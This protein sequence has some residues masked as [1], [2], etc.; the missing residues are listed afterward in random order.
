MKF[1]QIIILTLVLLLQTNI[2]F[3]QLRTDKLKNV[4][5]NI[6]FPELTSTEKRVLANQAQIFFNDLY[7]NRHQKNIMYGESPSFS[8]GHIDPL[9]AINEIVKNVDSLTT[10]ELEIG[11]Q[12]IFINQRDLHL[13][14]IFPAP[15][16]NYKSILPLTFSRVSSNGNF[17]E[18]RVDGVYPD[19]LTQSIGNQRVPEIGDIVIAYD[20]KNILEAVYDFKQTGQGANEY[21]GF[22]RAI[23]QMTFISQKIHE[24][25]KKDNVTITFLSAKN[26]E[27]YS[28]N[29]DWLCQWKEEVKPQDVDLTPESL[30]VNNNN[31]KDEPIDEDNFLSNDD[32]WQTEFNKFAADNNIQKNNIFPNNPTNEPVVKWG[33][34]NKDQHQF[35]YLKITSFVPVKGT[36]FAIDE[37]IRIIETH[38]QD[39]TGLIIDVRNNGGGSIV[40]ADKLSQLFIPG[41]ARAIQARLLNTD[42]NR[43]IFNDSIFGSFSNP[44]WKEV[45]NDVEGT[46]K[47]Y[48]AVAPFTTT[49]Q[50]NEIGQVY[51][52]PVAVM[53]NAR[54][55][56]ATDLFS[57][58]M[59]DNEAAIIFGEDPQTG[60]GGANV[61]EHQLFEQL[62]GAPFEKLPSDHAM[63]VSWRQSVRFGHHAGMLIEDHGCIADIKVSLIPSDLYDG[64]KSQLDTITEKLISQKK[65][66]KSYVITENKNRDMYLSRDSIKFN[67]TVSNTEHIDLYINN[68]FVKRDSVYIYDNEKNVIFNLPENLQSNISYSI[69]LIGKDSGNAPLWNMKRN[70]TILDKKHDI[71]DTGLKIDF[72]NPTNI[73]KLSIINKNTFPEDGWNQKGNYLAVGLDPVYKNQIDTDAVIFV[74]LTNRLSATLS[75]QLEGLTEKDYDFMTVYVINAN[76]K[77]ELYR[78]SGYMPNVVN[79]FDISEYSG[80]D[81]ISIHFRFI[82]DQMVDA[83][84]IRISS[85]NID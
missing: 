3:A 68:K 60:A 61:I 43:L 30:L 29:F 31:F 1:K 76:G 40:F 83:P 20:N 5:E 28:I 63:R 8:G 25:P 9:N 45:I 4:R 42:L 38:F 44:K 37:I 17:F 7:V 10:S 2:I 24:L 21:G 59:Q 69:A 15:Y 70:I 82:S 64:G 73:N 47:T 66:Y 16:K 36:P 46:S 62:V 57:C 72:T 58:A 85:I 27:K 35:G 78:Q 23:G 22:S 32:I 53:T 71:I 56:S 52:K 6:V 39:T 33:L 65:M 84:G 51:Y 77:K 79:S 67:L 50:A 19:L 75:F 12:K 81:N 49:A 48:S 41:E 34:I 18:V 14:Y 13:N 26:G 11:I 55:Y 74:N 54:S 80:Q